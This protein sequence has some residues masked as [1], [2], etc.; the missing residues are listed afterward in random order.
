[1]IVILCQEISEKFESCEIQR[2]TPQRFITSPPILGEKLYKGGL[3]LEK[4]RH[5]A[6][7]L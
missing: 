6:D 3:T 5:I 2:V 7:Y 4:I 1:M